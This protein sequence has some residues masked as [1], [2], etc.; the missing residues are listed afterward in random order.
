MIINNLIRILTPD[1]A[2]IMEYSDLIVRMSEDGEESD[3]VD[4]DLSKLTKSPK[5]RA[6]FLR[7]D[8]LQDLTRIKYPG[9][10]DSV[11]MKIFTTRSRRTSREDLFTGI[12]FL[13]PG[14]AVFIPVGLDS[15]IWWSDFFLNYT[16][17]DLPWTPSYPHDNSGCFHLAAPESLT[18]GLI[19]RGPDGFT[20]S[21]DDVEPSQLPKNNIDII[22]KGI[23]DDF[24]LFSFYTGHL[25]SMDCSS[26]LV[27]RREEALKLS[28]RWVYEDAFLKTSWGP[29]DNILVSYY[30]GGK[31]FEH[32]HDD[33]VVDCPLLLHASAE[34]IKYRLKKVHG[35]SASYDK[36]ELLV[37]KRLIFKQ[38]KYESTQLNQN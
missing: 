6:A 16:V 7:S 9:L 1:Y 27:N 15:S 2:K 10:P 23:T 36:D 22:N 12:I 19:Y 32:L 25:H 13:D 34:I 35:V 5:K 8:F 30:D 29:S 14:R 28:K 21:T 18:T 17:I 3:W 4:L 37:N 31:D 26:R 11:V 38:R 24:V 20:R 33:S